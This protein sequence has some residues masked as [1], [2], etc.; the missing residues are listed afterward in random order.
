MDINIEKSDSSKNM[1]SKIQHLKIC[2]SNYKINN[3]ET[4][5]Q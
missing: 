2:K 3:F 5:L 4:V 1:F